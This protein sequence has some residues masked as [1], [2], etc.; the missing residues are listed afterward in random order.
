T[1]LTDEARGLLLKEY[2]TVVAEIRW[3]N[4]KEHDLYILKFSLIGAVLGAISFYKGRDRYNRFN[5]PEVALCF[6]AAVA[7]AAIIDVR[8]M[9]NAV[10]IADL[11]KWVQTLEGAVLPRDIKG[12]EQL[13][14][15]SQL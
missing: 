10:I 7:V 4:E 9:F 6:W 3:R 2:D 12:W 1:N 13:F 14:S 8:L 15:E 11:G 5:G